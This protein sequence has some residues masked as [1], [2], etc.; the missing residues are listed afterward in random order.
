M[1]WNWDEIIEGLFSPK[2]VRHRG[3]PKEPLKR[4]VDYM[5]S[6]F[7]LRGQVAAL[8]SWEVRERLTLFLEHKASI[9]MKDVDYV[10]SLK[11]PLLS[12]LIYVRMHNFLKVKYEGLVKTWGEDRNQKMAAK[13]KALIVKIKKTAELRDLTF[14]YCS[15][16]HIGGSNTMSNVYEVHQPSKKPSLDYYDNYCA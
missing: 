5:L 9:F 15:T 6:E 3:R 12:H 10:L 16:E 11:V 14:T 8:D 13:L 2:T 4:S 7:R 1:D